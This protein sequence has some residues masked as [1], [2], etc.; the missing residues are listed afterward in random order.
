MASSIFQAILGTNPFSIT[1]DADENSVRYWTD[2]K[3]IAVE[4]LVSSNVVDQPLAL[5]AVT[6]DADKRFDKNFIN[7]LDVDTRNGKI[8]Q[9][10]KLR[11]KCMC[12]NLSTVES[13]MRY[14]EDITASF[15]ITSKAIIS[16]LMI[17]T[18]LAIT[19]STESLSAVEMVVEW[20]QAGRRVQ[21]TYDPSN[22][23]DEETFGVRIQQ[24]ESIIAESISSIGDQLTSAAKALYNKVQGTI[25]SLL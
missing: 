7:L 18:D 10:T 11:M 25:T 8:I 20:E 5:T 4:I 16:D 1:N 15:S 22:P 23:A 17:M 14:F 24:P 12:A 19:Q 9:P 2:L 6:H 21:A 3:I 13:M